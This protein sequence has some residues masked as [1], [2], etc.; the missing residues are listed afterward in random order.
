VEQVADPSPDPH[1]IPVLHW[2]ATPGVPPLTRYLLTG[3][4]VGTNLKDP[5]IERRTIRAHEIQG[6]YA[7]VFE[8]DAEAIL[9]RTRMAAVA[10][11]VLMALLVF[12]AAR[13]MFGAG[14][15]VIALGVLAFDPPFSWRTPA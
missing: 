3:P 13:K 8:N 1:Q 6:G 14:A 7:L 9:F 15:G 11:T 4:L 5:P 10:L 2:P 12:L